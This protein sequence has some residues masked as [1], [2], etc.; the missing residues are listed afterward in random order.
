MG[1]KEKKHHNHKTLFSRW[2]D[3]LDKY[4]K[5]ILKACR[6]SLYVVIPLWIATCIA[7]ILIQIKIS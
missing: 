5:A 6:Y 3:L 4:D 7:A 2:N 1:Y